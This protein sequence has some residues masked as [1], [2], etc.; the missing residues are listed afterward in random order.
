MHSD[1]TYLIQLTNILRTRWF[2]IGM[3]HS[4]LQPG[5]GVG[6]HP[7]V[8]IT[9][10]TWKWDLVETTAL[11]ITWHQSTSSNITYSS[12]YKMQKILTNNMSFAH[13]TDVTGTPGS[14]HS[15][16]HRYEEMSLTIQTSR[17]TASSCSY[18]SEDD[19]SNLKN[20][21]RS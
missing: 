10:R 16:I 5:S 12:T 8:G 21:R 15:T 9:S 18:F 3:H 14:T 20:E 11:R 19:R 1:A 7:C 4:P 6:G 2:A 13:H 17:Y